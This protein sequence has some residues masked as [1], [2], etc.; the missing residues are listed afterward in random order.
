MARLPTPGLLQRIL[1]RATLAFIRGGYK[2]TRI[3]AIAERADVSVGTIYRYV[4]NKE[5]LFDLVLRYAFDDPA[6]LDVALPYETTARHS[7]VEQVL[8]HMETASDLTTLMTSV[9]VDAPL[10]VASEFEGIVRELYAWHFRYWRGL[11]LIERCARDWP[12]VSMAFYKGYRETLLATGVRYLEKRTRSGHLRPMPDVAVAA[13]VISET[14]A[15]FAMHRHTAPDTDLPDDLA[16]ETV[17]QVLCS[18]FVPA[19]EEAGVG[20]LTNTREERWG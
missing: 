17:V 6:V 7:V 11:K 10:D 18:A 15:F 14:C 2:N 13:R 8:H 20:R 16:E 1:D 5:A 19:S 9:D 12:E 3:D 4:E